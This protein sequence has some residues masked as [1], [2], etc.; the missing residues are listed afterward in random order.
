MAPVDFNVDTELIDLPSTR[1][2]IRGLWGFEGPRTMI[3][4]WTSIAVIAYAW[5][6]VGLVVMGLGAQLATV[7]IRVGVV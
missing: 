7:M 6:A 2:L 1:A 5:G 4:A 3:V